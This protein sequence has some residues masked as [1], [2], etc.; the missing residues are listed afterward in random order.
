MLEL[1]G[2]R[3]EKWEL[4]IE[5]TIGVLCYMARGEVLKVL[6]QSDMIQHQEGLFR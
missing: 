4:E 2:E 1:S 6:I 3:V 5:R